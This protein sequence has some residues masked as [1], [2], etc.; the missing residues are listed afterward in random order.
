IDDTMASNIKKADGWGKALISNDGLVNTATKNGQ[1]L[2]SQLTELRDA[3]L[4][5]A[6]RA[7]EAGEQGLMPM[8]EAMLKAEGAME[9]GRAKAIALARDFGIPKE[10]AAALANQLGLVPST[11][12]TL[13]TAQGIPAAT[14]EVLGLTAKLGALK[15]G[16]SIP[17]K[18]PTVEARTQLELLGFSFQRIPGSKN[19]TVTA[20]TGTPRAHIAALA[21][22]IA[23]A[24]DKKKVTVQAIIQKAVGDLKGVQDKVAGLKEKKSITVSAPTQTAQKALK[25]L[26]Y[27]IEN[28]DKG[29]KKVRITAPTGDA[30][31][32]VQRIQGAINGITGRTVHVTV[33]YSE[34][35]KPSVVRTHADG[36]I[37][38]Y[39]NGGIRAATNR[40]KA[41]AAGAERHIA[42]IGK[43]GE[44]RIWNE[45]E[46]HGEAYIPLSP[47]K[48]KRSE[49]ILQ[50]VAEMFGGQVV[51]FANGA[52]R[53]YAQGAVRSTETK[54]IAR[55]R[56]AMTEAAP[57][58]VGGD[59][60]LTIG[61]V[62]STGT[63]LQDAM[64]ELHRIRLG[65]TYA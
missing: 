55:S 52:L 7:I 22:D 26:G 19:V 47:A 12:T 54:S 45:P 20:P 8:S 61:A 65:G 23:N 15:P 64:F 44:I 39:A 56:T 10:Q 53:Q 32:N 60:N 16:A 41:F 33:Q 49:A 28:V 42:Q 14:A 21:A 18:A 62:A 11:V 29:G 35:G 25:D 30:L 57:A 50:R 48:R 6:T 4:A 2:N 36:G 24:P 27:K 58:L 46:T 1:T 31:A 17:I 63:A 5:T 34:S 37:V 40:I 51:Y 3:M 38:H 59:L 43:P 13:V 9:S